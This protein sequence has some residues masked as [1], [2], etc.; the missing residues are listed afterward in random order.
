[1]GVDARP[2]FMTWQQTLQPKEA[3]LFSP[4]WTS[5]SGLRSEDM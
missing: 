3:S 5:V 2:I 1:M 4:G